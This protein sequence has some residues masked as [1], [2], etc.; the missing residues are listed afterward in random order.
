MS[1]FYLTH[2][3]GPGYN[4]RN[5]AHYRQFYL[6]FNDIEILHT[7]VQNLTWSH[8]RRLLS[9]NDPEARGWYLTRASEDMWSVKTLD[10][11]ICSQYYERRLADHRKR[12][13]DVLSE[14]V[15][16]YK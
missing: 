14:T 1:N 3:F 16:P 5:L 13:N 6:T 7:R 9:V 11:N 8:I 12:P 15:A 4:K 10:R 2:E